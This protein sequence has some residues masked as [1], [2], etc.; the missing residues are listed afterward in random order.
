MDCK[1]DKSPAGTVPCRCKD[2]IQAD[3]PGEWEPGC[4]LGNNAKFVKV[5][6]EPSQEHHKLDDKLA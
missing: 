5:H 4:D 6:V 1:T 2:R 3:C